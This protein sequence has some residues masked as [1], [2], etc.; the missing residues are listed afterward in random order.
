M[1]TTVTGH[2]LFLFVTF[3]DSQIDW[4]LAEAI[5]LLGQGMENVQGVDGPPSDEAFA[6]GR[7]QFLRAEPSSTTEQQIVHTA[8]S[9]SHGLIRLE[10]ATLEPIKGYE[11]GLRELVKAAGGSV[12]TLAGVMRP[13]SYTSHAMSEFAYAH[14][15]PPGSGE[16][17]PLA[18]VTLM[19]KTDDWW[20]MDFLHR[21][22][23]FLPRYDENEEMV[24]KGHALA[25]A[26]GVPDINRRLVHSPDG[27]GLG[28]SY[29]FV[30]YF[31][32]AEADAPVFREVMAGLRDTVQ[33]PE[34]KYVLE[35]PEWWGRRVNTAA[36]F[37]ARP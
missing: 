29:D 19:N 35:G 24:V 27:Y 21:E 6:R 26:M 25:S 30:G 4:E 12:E 23:F 28:G 18:A 22:S 37:L 16:K 14:A 10:C 11:N 34:W 17:F 7:F 5:D 32:F 8:V 20:Q 1:T 3:G 31:E 2:Q 36:E 33:N 13:R 15:M 9:E